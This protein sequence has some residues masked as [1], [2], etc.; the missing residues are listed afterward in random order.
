M[1]SLQEQ[2]QNAEEVD[3]A[4]TSSLNALG[5]RLRSDPKQ[6]T[7]DV[8]SKPSAPRAEQTESAG[9]PTASGQLYRVFRWLGPF[10]THD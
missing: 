6:H 9:R 8:K 4:F 1:S 2:E 5:A 3:R 7:S 10:S